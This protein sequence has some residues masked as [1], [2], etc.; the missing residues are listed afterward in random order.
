MTIA[1][2]ED[3]I[4]HPVYMNEH[5]LP[6]NQYT[7]HPCLKTYCDQQPNVTATTCLGITGFG[8]KFRSEPGVHVYIPTWTTGFS[9]VA[10]KALV[11]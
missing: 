4:I 3:E 9:T 8:G 7:Q 2:K 10:S 5:T 6:V 1:R 11:T